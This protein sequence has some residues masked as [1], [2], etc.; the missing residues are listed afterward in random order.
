MFV[1]VKSTP[2]S[3]RQS[4]QIVQSV[5]EGDKVRQKILR[6]VG[7]AMNDAELVKLKEVAEFVKSQLQEEHQASLFS[8]EDATQQAIEAKTTTK[9]RGA[10]DRQALTVDLRRLKETQRAVV[11]IHEVFGSIYRQLGFD[12]LWGTSKRYHKR[13]KL[14][15][16]IVMARIAQPASKRASVELLERDFGIRL[17]LSSIYKMMDAMDEPTIEKLQCLAGNRTKQLLGGSLSVLFYDCTT[18]Y[19]ESFEPDDLRQKGFSK[20]RKASE[21]QVL[22]ALVVSE[23]GLPVGYEVFPGATFEGHTLIPILQ[24]LKQRFDITRV[25]FVADRGLFNKDNLDALEAAKVEYVVGTRLKNQSETLKR[26]I[27]DTE[28]YIP[29]SE[30]LKVLTL[31]RPGGRRMVVTHSEKRARKDREDRDKSILKM[32][33]KLSRSKQP[34]EFIASSSYKKYLKVP[35]S[36]VI[37]V[38]Q[39][40]VTNSAQWDGLHGVITNA[41]EA[42]TNTIL[43]HYR[44]LW[45]IEESFRIQKHDLKVRP[46]FHWTESRIRAHLAI[47]FMAFC[48]VRHLAY[49]VALQYKKLS[50]E[51]IRRELAHVQVSLLEDQNT[52][53]IY[54]MPSS[55]SPDAEKIYQVMGIKPVTTAYRIS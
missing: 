25:V 16:H 6:H 54:G 10:A 55:V 8:P 33:K 2:N 46:I 41:P 7:V 53:S 40:A 20:D 38:D 52:Q 32:K 15:E 28:S 35:A 27:L 50:P 31:D 3:P 4:V 19:F 21:T 22:L 42:D 48:C 24:Q 51:V 39:E 11:G 49:R 44:G 37:S 17:N 18:L 23:E 14:L 29:L 13:R 30:G 5:R 45:A 1:R 34:K 12:T 47:A 36:G 26:Q 9:A 43:A